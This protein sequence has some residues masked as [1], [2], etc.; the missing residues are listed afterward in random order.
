MFRLTIE[1]AEHA[2]RHFVYKDGFKVTVQYDN[3]KSDMACAK[4]ICHI[5]LNMVSKGSICNQTRLHPF[6]H[7][8]KRVKG[9]N[10]LISM[11]T[12]LRN[13]SNLQFN[14]FS[15]QCLYGYI[16]IYVYTYIY[17]YI[18]T[19]IYMYLQLINTSR[20]TIANLVHGSMSILTRNA[21]SEDSGALECRMERVNGLFSR[22]QRI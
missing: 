16:Y 8:L 19:Y 14:W 3:Y 6:M 13:S 10:I 11:S 18:Y 5:Y 12:I 17:I 7:K 21:T 4:D 9:Q 1:E 15:I 2:H 22:S 20:I